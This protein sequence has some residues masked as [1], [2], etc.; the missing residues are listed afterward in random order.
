MKFSPIEYE[1]LYGSINATDDIVLRIHDDG[2][3]SLVVLINLYGGVWRPPVRIVSWPVAVTKDWQRLARK[4]EVAHNKVLEIRDSGTEQS[5]ND[6]L[7]TMILALYDFIEQ[8]HKDAKK[9]KHY[10]LAG[11]AQ[12]CLTRFRFYT[13]ASADFDSQ[14]EMDKLISHC[15]EARRRFGDTLVKHGVQFDPPRVDEHFEYKSEELP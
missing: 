12:W 9:L 15:R 14:K 8:V 6:A 7:R 11:F 10:H 4:Y 5:F 2:F 3:V 1:Q 13:H